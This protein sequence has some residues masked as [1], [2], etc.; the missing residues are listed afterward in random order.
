LENPLAIHNFLNPEGEDDGTNRIFTNQEFIDMAGVDEE[1]VEEEEE[2]E[3]IIPFLHGISKE[4]QIQ[5]FAVVNA[6]YEE[7]NLDCSFLKDLC[8]MQMILQ[9]EIRLEKEEHQK[10][11][12]ISKYFH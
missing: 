12:P 2:E 1:E 5:A 3:E 6:V 4:E 8:S 11:T 7:C 10:Q 9:S